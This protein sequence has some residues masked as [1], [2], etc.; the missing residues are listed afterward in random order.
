MPL[1]AASVP[2]FVRKPTFKPRIFRMGSVM[3]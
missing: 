2:A 1:T 3:A